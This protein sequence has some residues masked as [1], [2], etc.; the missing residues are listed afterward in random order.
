LPA[1]ATARDL[2]VVPLERTAEVLAG[3]AP[4]RA[5]EDPA[6]ADWDADDDPDDDDDEGLS[7]A[8]TPHPTVTEA[9]SPR[10]KTAPPSH[11]ECDAEA[12]SIG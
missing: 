3:V 12:A 11:Q 2:A 1:G 10:A 9:P 4:D 7:A 5:D 8:A 6:D